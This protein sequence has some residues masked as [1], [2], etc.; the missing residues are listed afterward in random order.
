MAANYLRIAM[1]ENNIVANNVHNQIN[2]IQELTFK[3]HK[4]REI[5]Y[6]VTSA[7]G[8]IM[9]ILYFFSSFRSLISSFSS[10]YA[11]ISATAIVL[12]S[13]SIMMLRV[14]N[15]D[16]FPW[17]FNNSKNRIDSKAKKAEL[18]DYLS[19]PHVQVELLK[20]LKFSFSE[21]RLNEVKK[22][23]A[24]KQYD[25]ADRLISKMIQRVVDMEEAKIEEIKDQAIIN[26]YEEIL[27]NTI[28]K[29]FYVV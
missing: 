8:F 25:K 5:F 4:S 10:I 16:L 29:K 21:D 11:L 6:I 2:E 9:L 23:F 18:F 1:F 27:E 3:L 26:T 20:F 7:I 17:L 12:G 13:L 14:E 22:C 24:L 19:K 28:E 15:T